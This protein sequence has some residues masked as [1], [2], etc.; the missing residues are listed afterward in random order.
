MRRNEKARFL[1]L[2]AMIIGG[3]LVLAAQN[4]GENAKPEPPAAAGS[5]AAVGQPSSLTDE[6]GNYV[7]GAMDILDISVWKEPEISRRVPVRPDGKISLPLL[8]D[9]EAAGL[10]PMRL[11]ERIT[12]GLKKFVTGPQ[13]TVT[14]LEI[15]SKRIFILGEVARRGAIPMLPNMTV[16]Q[17]ISSAGG[18]GQFANTKKIYVMRNE[19]G[20]QFTFPFNYNEVI[21]GNRP[22]QNFI[23]KPGDTIVVP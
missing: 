1:A 11:Q 7:I 14:V 5:N 21:K 6:S 4:P 18:F 23:L 15:N 13:V 9:I 22:E 17:A 2:L 16:L 19:N 3:A 10:T 20:K 12:E 8:N